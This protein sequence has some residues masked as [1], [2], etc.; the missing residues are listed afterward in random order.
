[1]REQDQDVGSLSLSRISFK[2]LLTWSL[3]GS[4]LPHCYQTK[5]KPSRRI[6]IEMVLYKLNFLFIFFNFPLRFLLLS[7]LGKSDY[8]QG[9]LKHFT[10]NQW[11]VY[12]CTIF[13]MV[14]SSHRYILICCDV[15]NFFL[16]PEFYMYIF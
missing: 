7:N 2:L 11:F 14:Q 16:N 8:Y 6:F 15:Y 1:M 3:S 5:F 13:C 10:S 9:Q 4:E 12:W